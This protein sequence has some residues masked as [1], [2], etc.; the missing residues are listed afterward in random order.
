MDLRLTKGSSGVD[1]R[2]PGIRHRPMAMR[3]RSLLQR[4][5]GSVLAGVRVYPDC[6][7]IRQVKK[8]RGGALEE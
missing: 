6:K 3:K 7:P 5:K 2:G 1:E 8:R 4:M